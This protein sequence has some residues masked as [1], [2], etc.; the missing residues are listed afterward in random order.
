[1]LATTG[2]CAVSQSIIMRLEY[3]IGFVLVLREDHTKMFAAMNG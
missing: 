1:M 3:E 2:H